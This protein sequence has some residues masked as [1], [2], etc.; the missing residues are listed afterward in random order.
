MRPPL[1]L[2]TNHYLLLGKQPTTIQNIMN[3]IKGK[4]LFF[5]VFFN[6]IVSKD[7]I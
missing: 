5:M 3:T 4:R 7:R 1:I 6:C 2:T